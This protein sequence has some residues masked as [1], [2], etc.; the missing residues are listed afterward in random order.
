[1]IICVSDSF[2]KDYVG[3]AEL[4][5][6]AIIDSSL[7]PCMTSYSHRVTVSLM[8]EYKDSFWIFGNFANLSKECIL[9][10]L[11]N[12]KYIVL[13][14]DYKYC[15]FR[16]PEKHAQAE[17]KCDCNLKSTGKLISLFYNNAQTVWWMSYGQRERYQRLFPF[18]KE[19]KNKVLSSVFSDETIELIENLDISEKNENWIILN[20]NSW[21]KGVEDAVQYAKENNLKYE[22]VWGLEYEKLLEKMAKSK[23]LIFFP[24]AADTCPRLVIEAKLLNCELILNDN[25]QHKD[26][27]WFQNRESILNYLKNRTEMFWDHFELVNNLETPNSSLSKKQT[28]FNIVVPLYNAER[29][30]KKC[31]TSIKRQKYSNFRCFL[32]DDLSDDKSVCVINKLTEQDERFTLIQNK[33]KKYA[34]GNIANILNCKDYHLESEDVNIILDGDDWFS[35]VH[36]LEYLNKVYNEESCLLTYG[37]YVY[38]PWATKGIEPSKYPSD[39]IENNNFREDKWRASHLR[40]FKQLLWNL[41]DMEDLQGDDGDYYKTAYDQALMLPM[42]EMAGNKIKYLSKI[43]HVYNRS[44]PI[45]VDKIK[46]HEQHSTSQ[47]IR[48]QKKYKRLF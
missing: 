14:Y 39:V 7:Y 28:R 4:T 42:L 13:E 9:Y 44:N 2:V 45:N 19:N 38:H 37:S 10:A 47:E 18:L 20:S 48:K 46:Q 16:S 34:L 36:V 29:W 15:S 12:L 26:E 21:I 17:G 25:V 5:T 22:L 30:L 43:L 23:G 33:T 41:I 11:K 40:T 8:K 27:D 6:Q 3:G 31:I 35:S 24:R 1:M 32:I